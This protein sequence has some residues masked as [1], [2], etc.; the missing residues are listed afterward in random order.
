MTR[1]FGES[2]RRHAVV[3]IMLASFLACASRRTKTTDPAP[4][5]ADPAPPRDAGGRT[6]EDL[7]AG[8]FPGVTVARTTDG[9]LAIRIRGGNNSFYASSEPLFV[10][11]ETPLPAGTGG[12]VYLDPYDIEKIEVLKNPADIAFYGMRGMN[13]VIRITTRRPGTR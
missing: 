11:D 4:V 7:F 2:V 12:I 1:T 13:G 6:L 8:R 5:A 3:A 10:V 9:G